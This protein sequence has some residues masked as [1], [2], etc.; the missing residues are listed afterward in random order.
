MNVD[1]TMPLLIKWHS[2]DT[3]DTASLDAEEIDRIAIPDTGSYMLA[4]GALKAEKDQART[5]DIDL[6]RSNIVIPA[7]AI[8][9]SQFSVRVE[10]RLEI[11]ALP[12]PA[13]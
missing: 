12:N 3:A 1:S 10:N 4:P 8:G 7:G 2:S 13:L 6:T 5:N 11:V 9:D